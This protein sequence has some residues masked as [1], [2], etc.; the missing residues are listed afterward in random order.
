MQRLIQFVRPARGRQAD[1]RQH[2]VALRGIIS[3]RTS[4]PPDHPCSPVETLID[5]A[6]VRPKPGTTTQHNDPLG[7]APTASSSRR[8][9][10]QIGGYAR[11]FYRHIRAVGRLAGLGYGPTRAG[12][13]YFYAAAPAR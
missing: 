5:A 10:E 3:L 12:R 2:L 1:G 9:S 11:G 8:R 6:L 7:T 4:Q 13:P